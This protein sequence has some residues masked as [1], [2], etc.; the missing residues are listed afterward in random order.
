MTKILNVNDLCDAICGSTLDDSTQR[1]LIGAV[2]AAVRRAA[3]VLAHRYG[4]VSGPAEYETGFGG[5][6]VN[7]RPAHVGQE[8]PDVIDAGDEGGNWPGGQPG[9]I[10]TNVTR[11]VLPP[12]QGLT[13]IS[14]S[15]SKPVSMHISL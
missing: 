5:L 14:T 15:R 9:H 10:P 8:C 4:I 2:E 11:P 1:I 3:N 12:S 6:C 7:F 13:V